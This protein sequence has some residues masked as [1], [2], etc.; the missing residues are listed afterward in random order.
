MAIDISIIEEFY[1]IGMIAIPVIYDT[2][3][4]VVTL[5]PEH[6]KDVHGPGGLPCLDDSKR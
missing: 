5:H 2:T 3:A 4:K 6:E 1:Q